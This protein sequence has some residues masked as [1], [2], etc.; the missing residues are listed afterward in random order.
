MNVDDVLEVMQYSIQTRIRSA[1]ETGIRIAN[2]NPVD[3]EILITA[4][5]NETFKGIIHD[6]DK[7]MVLDCTSDH[8]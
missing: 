1:I 5:R 3:K 7:Q 8:K 2:T 4:Y 6:F